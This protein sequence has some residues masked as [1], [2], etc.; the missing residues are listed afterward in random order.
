MNE[1]APEQMSK[2]PS[3]DAQN[4]E[5]ETSQLSEQELAQVT[6]GC[7]A[8]THMGGGGGAGLIPAV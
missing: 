6:G 8:G 5:R 7:A 2:T 3:T 4:T 1:K